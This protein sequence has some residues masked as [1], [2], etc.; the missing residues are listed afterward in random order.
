[1]PRFVILARPISKK[2]WTSDDFITHVESEENGHRS[3]YMLKEQQHSLNDPHDTLLVTLDNYDLGKFVGLKPPKEFTFDNG[4][5]KKIEYRVEH[6][7][8]DEVEPRESITDGGF[9]QLQCQWCASIIPSNGAAQYAHL[10]KHIN[11]LVN[12]N[13]L[14]VVQG[15]NIR[16]TKLSDEHIELFKSVFINSTPRLG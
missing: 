2:N 14:T 11:H 5:M 16:S 12:I 13:K 10:R 7:I 6:K 8:K 1:M 4:D 9:R 3:A 15:N